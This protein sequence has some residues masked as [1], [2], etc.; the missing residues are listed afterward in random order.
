MYLNNK[1][2]I[3]SGKWIFEN[4]KIVEDSVT[5]RIYKLI[6]NH[7][8]K[9]KNDATGWKTLYLDPKDN[10]YWELT[11]ENS[12]WQGGGPPTLTNVRDKEAKSR[13]DL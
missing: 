6:N 13:Y 4:G 7:L 11:Y 5:K 2:K 1:E 3:L 8:V 12:D 9:V 10:R